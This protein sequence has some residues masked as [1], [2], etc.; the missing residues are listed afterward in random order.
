MALEHAQSLRGK[1]SSRVLGTTGLRES[2]QAP[3]PLFHLPRE[4]RLIASMRGT[5]DSCHLWR[6]LYLLCS[7]G[8]RP[9]HPPPPCISILDEGSEFPFDDHQ[10]CLYRYLTAISLPRLHAFNS[11][12]PNTYVAAVPVPQP[13]ASLFQG[14]CR[15]WLCHCL[16]LAWHFSIAPP[17][18][19][20]ATSRLCRNHWTAYVGELTS[21]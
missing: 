19:L 1:S 12:L 7:R 13:A 20:H 2:A 8:P 9:C 3:P 18:L 16:C 15:P 21:Y 5:T 6:A 17:T 10:L 11:A 4:A 14:L